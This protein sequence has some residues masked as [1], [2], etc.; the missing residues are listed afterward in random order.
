MFP[1]L[2][3][4]TAAVIAGA[5][6]S[7]AGGGTLISFPALVWMGR[8]PIMANATNAVALW[9]GS[10]AAAYGFRRELSTVRR[11]LLMLVIPSLLGGAVGA[12]ILLRTPSLVF[13]HIVPFLILG[14]TLLLAAQEMITKR[15]GILARAH[16]TPTVGWIVFVFVFQFLVGLYGGYFGG[17]MGILM[18]AALGLIGMTDMHQMNGLKNIFA[19]CVNGIAAILFAVA[20][21]VIWHDVVIMTIG[22]I[23]G[24][25]LGARLA[26]RLGRTFV[27][28]AV[29][30]IGLVMTIAMLVPILNAQEIQPPS[31]A[32]RAIKAHIDFLASDLLEGREAGSRGHEIAAAYVAAQFEA[33]GLDTHLQQVRFRTFKI[34][35]AHSSFAIDGKPF[36]HRKDVLIGTGLDAERDV[37]AEVVHAG[38]GTAEDY[39]NIDARGKI[40]AVLSGASPRLEPT[41]RAL[42]S[43]TY[44][45][46]RV[47][48]EHGAIGVVTIRTLETER[49]FSWARIMDQDDGTSF[50]A[51][52]ETGAPMEAVPQIRATAALGPTAAAALFRDAP[53]PLDATLADAEKGIAHAFPLRTRVAIHVT[54][55]LGDATSPNV[56]GLVRGSDPQRASELVVL[57]AHLDHLGLAS[58]GA[59]RVRNGALDNGSGIAAL[60]E[61]ARKVASMARKP[62][63]SIVFVAVTAEEK[64]EQGSLAFAEKPSVAGTM[65]ANVN[66][67]MLTMLFPMQSLVALGMEHSTLGPLARDAAQRAGFTLQNDPQPEEV[68]FIRSDQYSFVKKGVP[69]ITYKGGFASRDPK[70]DGEKLTRDWLRNT[71]H[72][73]GDGPDQ[74]LDYESGARWAEANYNLVVAI[75]DAKERPRWNAGS[76]FAK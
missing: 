68:R 60:L 71:Y 21:A 65:V 64:G 7:I 43:D 15:L 42:A 49:R 34:D 14:A 38:F 63:R 76:A 52:D 19:V 29:V 13:E 70:I 62:A 23:I 6:N 26:R 50:R 58:K 66:M 67:D 3:I 39:A 41:Q 53:T 30:V 8:D 9:P 44:N 1:T 22:T 57:T 4:F 17:G 40:V 74:K 48:A 24:G 28:R 35:P 55:T 56:V 11:W 5:I 10:L 75:A 33:A 25:L 47:A 16:E 27:R 72:S 12:W 54:T 61:I 51:L 37:E 20:G 46:L 69:A 31:I 73:V 45:K 2:V 59:D 32:P 36:E 18:L